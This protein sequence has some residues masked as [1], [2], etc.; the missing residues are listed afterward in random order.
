VLASQTARLR[1]L[2]DDIGLVSR[3]EERQLPL[4]LVPVAL[5]QLVATAVQAARPG[6][7]KKGVELTTR[8]APGLPDL[9]ADP[10]RLTQVLAGLLDNARRHTPPGGQVAVSTEAAG[11]DVVITVTDSGAGIA[12]EHLPHIFE[13]FYRADTARDRA[14]GGSGIG[15]TI[16]R[17]LVTAHGGTLTAASDGPGTGARFTITLP[18]AANPG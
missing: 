16:G 1:R 13:R 17:A 3:V 8:L 2:A 15:L 5:N 18:G 9:A 11:P 12:A 4:H 10:E 14:H 6:Y 7:E